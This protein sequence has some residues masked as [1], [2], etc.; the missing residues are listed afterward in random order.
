ATRSA[1]EDARSSQHPGGEGRR[2]RPAVVEGR[3]IVRRRARERGADVARHGLAP[4]GR[5]VD[6][7]PAQNERGSCLSRRC[8]VEAYAA[9]APPFGSSRRVRN[10]ERQKQTANVEL[11]ERLG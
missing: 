2:A 7:V 3:A 8:D 9:A 4:G 11:S 6:R 5:I 10:A 1:R